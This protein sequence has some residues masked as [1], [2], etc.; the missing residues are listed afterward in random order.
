MKLIP[1]TSIVVPPDRQRKEFPA[2]KMRELEESILSLGL[3][4]PI[5]V[6]E[7]ESEIRL[8]A[9]ERRM[10]CLQKIAEDKM[11]Y[12]CDGVEIEP[13]LAACIR[14]SDLSE[15]ELR[16][17]ELDENI[18]RQELSWQERC[19]ALNGLLALRREQAEKKGETVTT[20]AIARELADSTDT[21]VEGARAELAR[22]EFVSTMMTHP[23]VAEAR[24]LREA[25]T[26]AM[27]I[28]DSELT[29]ALAKATG[30]TMSEHV[31]IA[32]DCISAMSTLPLASFDC[33]ITDPP[34]GMGA[35]NFGNAGPV[36]QYVDDKAGAILIASQII[37]H[38]AI[39][40]K[41]AAHLYMFCDID[42]FHELRAIAERQGFK[43][44]RTPLIWDKGGAL[45]HNPIPAQG[46]RRSYETIL[47]AYRGDKP[48]IVFMSDVIRGISTAASP[49]HPAEKPAALYRHLLQR[50]CRPGD[51]VL[52]P[53]CGTGAVFEAATSLKLRATGIEIDPEYAKIASSRRFK[54]FE[55]QLPAAG[56]L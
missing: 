16:E 2:A 52:D 54:S 21:S 3:M 45:G 6:R 1:L 7:T 20:V 10:R 14:T 9:G 55:A 43:P 12:F 27:K 38:A 28:T 4:H 22:A 47:Y 46:L 44:W 11:I 39:L 30:E 18:K 48:G 25:Y 29:A 5:V 32:E 19:G 17:A 41:E 23:K 34:Y 42:Q 33:V 24:S 26:V 37:T 50:S 31:M 53:C 15:L 56:D 8:V 13:G 40:C 51:T 49:L 36:H 35:D